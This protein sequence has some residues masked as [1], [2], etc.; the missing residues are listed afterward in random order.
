MTQFNDEE[1]T[2][3]SQFEHQISCCLDSS[4]IRGMRAADLEKLRVIWERVT[5]RPYYLN[6]SCASCIFTFIK[7]LGTEYRR[8]KTEGTKKTTK[9]GKK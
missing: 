2:F 9:K 8:Q 4:Y 3:I 5:G 6:S 1:M 7:A